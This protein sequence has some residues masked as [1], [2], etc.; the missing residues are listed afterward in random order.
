MLIVVAREG[1][2]QTRYLN[3]E[4]ER[5]TALCLDLE[6]L[7]AGVLPSVESLE[8][9]PFLDNYELAMRGVPALKGRVVAHP[10]IGTTTALTSEV[11]VM[12]PGLGWARTTSRFYRLGSP[13]DAIARRFS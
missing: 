8:D 12:A 4:I 7:R 6:R 9:A 5:L 13:C 10:I 3:E 2:L 11:F 1:V